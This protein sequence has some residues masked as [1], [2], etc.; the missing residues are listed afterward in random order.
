MPPYE[1]RLRFADR[2][3]RMI[4]I[5]LLFLMLLAALFQTT[6][7]STIPFPRSLDFKGDYENFISCFEEHAK[8]IKTDGVTSYR[9]GFI[10]PENRIRLG[11]TRGLFAPLESRAMYI[12][13]ED[14]GFKIVDGYYEEAHDKS[15]PI[16]K[17]DWVII[18]LCGTGTL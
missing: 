11:Q 5:F 16:R 6:L 10:K 14:G 7:L 2:L 4:G 18:W 17:Y 1:K 15:K 12:D 3:S 9:R 8:L 13:L